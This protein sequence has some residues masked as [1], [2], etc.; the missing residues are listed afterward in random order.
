MTHR[1]RVYSS[2]E[3]PPTRQYPRKRNVPAHVRNPQRT[4]ETQARSHETAKR[5]HEAEALDKKL[6]QLL[7]DPA[8]TTVEWLEGE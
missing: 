7:G 1:P 3:T 6:N 8:Y 2:G 4:P 5:T